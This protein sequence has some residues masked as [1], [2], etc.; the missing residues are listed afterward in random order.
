MAIHAFW[1][2]PFLTLL[3]S[4]VSTQEPLAVTEQIPAEN[5][6]VVLAETPAIIKTDHRDPHDPTGRNIAVPRELLQLRQIRTSK[7]ALRQGPGIQFELE[8][9]LLA[10]GE[11]VVALMHSKLWVYV[12]EPVSRARGWL[13]QDS[14]GPLSLEEEERLPATLVL[15][16]S[17]LPTVFTK[18]Q[19]GLVQSY[20]RREPR[21]VAI[22]SGQRF[23]ALR[24]ETKDILLLTPSQDGVF[25][26]RRS[27]L[28]L[29]P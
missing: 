22:S 17:A 14:L 2:L 13:H 23:F 25:Y 9:K 18:T 29:D 1:C 27:H 24:S 5:I 6:G 16:V 10:S 7:G 4:C 28:D 21:K 11:S 15:D 8:D 26:L 3:G 20:P 19:V 12:L